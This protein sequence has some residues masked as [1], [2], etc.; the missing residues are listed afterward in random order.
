VT[1]FSDLV[2]NPIFFAVELELLVRLAESQIPTTTLTCSGLLPWCFQNTRHSKLACQMCISNREKG[3]NRASLGWHKDYEL[4]M[5]VDRKNA[6]TEIAEGMIKKYRFS[7]ELEDLRYKEVLIGPGIIATLSFTLKTSNVE[8]ASCKNL[9]LNLLLTS[10]II[11]EVLPEAFVLLA[12]DALVVG[13]GRLASNWT[14]SRVAES[15]GI[16]VFA[17][18][19]LPTQSFYLAPASPAGALENV[20]TSLNHFSQILFDGDHLADAESFFERQRFPGSHKKEIP[21]LTDKN[22]F[23]GLQ[24][25]GNL[26]TGFSKNHRNVAI[27]LSSEWEYA[28]LPEWKNRLGSSQGEIIKE[29]LEDKNLSPEI[30]V[31]IRFHPHQRSVQ[32]E[33]DLVMSLLGEN[34]RYIFPD[35]EVD[36]YALLE[37]CEKII[38]FGSTMGAEATFW[39]VP[40]ILCGRSE[41]ETLDATYNPQSNGELVDLI[42]GDIIAKDRLKILPYGLLRLMRGI[43]WKYAEIN[44][45]SYP[46]IQGKSSSTVTVRILDFL[47]R[48]FRKIQN[49]L[50]RLP[51]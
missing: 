19:N 5:P 51:R 49:G 3:Q 13:N 4:N 38:T 47:K 34:C 31:W 50:P 30:I 37:A 48:F 29:L 44:Y 41:Y 18:E 46:I 25:R 16:K 27:F 7:S 6:L 24:T 15:M 42:N 2:L 17:Y 21:A 26:P 10:L 33:I 20:Q 22:I 14:A 45:P 32:H 40:S 1:I 35:E 11:V 39:G 8:L 23:L 28:G 36:S 12:P 9:A 43:D